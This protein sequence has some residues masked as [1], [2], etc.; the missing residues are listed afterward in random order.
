MDKEAEEQ[1]ALENLR[2]IGQVDEQVAT[3]RNAKQRRKS[4]WDAMKVH[5]TGDDA[6][7]TSVLGVVR[8][9]TSGGVPAEPPAPAPRALGS[10]V[11]AFGGARAVAPPPVE[12]AP[13]SAAVPARALGP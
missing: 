7:A 9:A 1:Q 11:A 13:A 6:P 3:A 8:R 4:K 10:A 5:V 12:E 2:Y